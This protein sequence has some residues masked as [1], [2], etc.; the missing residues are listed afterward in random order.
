MKAKNVIISSVLGL[1]VGILL[2]KVIS[3]MV[4]NSESVDAIDSKEEPY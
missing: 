1:T 2:Y 4:V 3:N